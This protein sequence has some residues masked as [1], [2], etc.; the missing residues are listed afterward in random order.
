M[1][2]SAAISQHARERKI[3][4]AF[5]FVRIANMLCAAILLLGAVYFALTT[6]CAIVNF[7]W[8]Q[9]MFDQYRTYGTFLN[10]PFP[11]NVL[12]PDNGHR[13][14]IPNLIRA[15]EIRWFAADQ[16]L[17]I[18]LGT[19][20]ILFT[21]GAL[22][23]CAWRERSLPLPMRAAGV[24]FAV[25]GVLWL[26][27]ARMLM[28]GNESLHAYL[29]TSCV[30]CAALFTS[31]A[32]HGKPLAWLAAASLAAAVATFSFGP[33]IATFAA[34]LALGVLLRLSWRLLALPA[35][36]MLACLFVY[37]FVLPGN[38][39]VRG[40][41][42]FHPLESLIFAARWIS[43]PWIGGWLGMAD[44]QASWV[45]TDATT[46]QGRVMPDAA[47]TIVRASG[48]SWRSLAT[49][50][51][52]A[53]ACGFGVR[54]L[55]A[56]RSGRQPDRLEAV[57]I[58]VCV[59]ALA[60]ALVIGIGRLGYLRTFPDQ[61]FADRYSI[62]PSLFWSA[63]AMLLLGSAARSRSRIA[64]ILVIAFA[65]LLPWMLYETHRTLAL[66]NEVVYRQ[67]QRT[68]AALRSGVFD[69]QNFQ[70]NGADALAND[71]ATIDLLREH[72][73][74]M[75]AD[76][77]W[78]R[79]GKRWTGTIESSAMYSASV[80]PIEAFVDTWN[81]APAAHVEGRIVQGIARLQRDGQLAVLDR[82]QIVVGLA[83]FSFLAP[84][85]DPL[86]LALPRKRGFDAYIAHYDATNSY[87][88]VLLEN[89]TSAAISL[90][91]LAPRTAR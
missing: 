36:T 3:T 63:F 50:I 62:W 33:G 34:V 89:N 12:Q 32:R 31:N 64:P 72:R 17:Q 90:A 8:R 66:W 84:N 24:M 35:A 27:N 86:P 78:E 2:E 19:L 49:F 60:S 13:P 43:S 18:T 67:A 91:Q 75:F 40:V 85:P 87:T 65:M 21:T 30:V 14:I 88:L 1:S 48:L 29:V 59:F 80:G 76:P 83:Q 56:F 52:A 46:L 20:L 71:Q 6:L 25:L 68:A 79:V 37:V 70:G 55:L 47:N 44:P 39:S 51:G 81:Q 82:N 45:F 22:A 15:A 16:L 73:L 38:E 61:V 9:P 7:S 74:A 77:G 10:L 41:L 26:G 58:G 57:A 28:H 42:G 5:P 4:R 11:D 69:E 54:A 23:F 53:G